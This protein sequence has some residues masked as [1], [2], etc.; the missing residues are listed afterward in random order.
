M[1]GVLPMYYNITREGGGWGEWGS[2]QS[3]LILHRGGLQSLLQYDNFEWKISQICIMLNMDDPSDCM[4]WSWAPPT[5]RMCRLRALF[6]Y[7][8]CIYSTYLVG[9]VHKKRSFYRQ[10]DRKG[11]WG[12]GGSAPSSPTVSECENL[13][14]AIRSFCDRASAVRRNWGF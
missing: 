11:G 12:A 14:T 4:I 2:S 5:K 9:D 3:I 7:T 1:E 8:S 13:N 6:I 10:A